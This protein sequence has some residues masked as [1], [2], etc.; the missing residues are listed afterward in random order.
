MCV[1][2]C[3]CANGCHDR[4]GA[5]GEKK[6]GKGKPGMWIFFYRWQIKKLVLVDYGF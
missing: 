3:V 5:P 1:C 4:V 2:V 6:V